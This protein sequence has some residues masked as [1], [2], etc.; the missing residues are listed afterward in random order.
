MFSDPRD[1]LGVLGVTK[2]QNLYDTWIPLKILPEN[3]ISQLKISKIKIWKK[4]SVFSVL[5]DITSSKKLDVKWH[6]ISGLFHLKLFKTSVPGFSIFGTLGPPGPHR[7]VQMRVKL[8]S[9]HFRYH[10]LETEIDVISKLNFR[11]RAN[12]WF[13]AGLYVN[14][15]LV[16][17]AIQQIWL[18][19]EAN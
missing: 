6:N 7:G 2:H 12:G 9:M 15:W 18:D 16:Y 19:E 11:I 3:R 8:I 1:P 5:R 17:N 4:F 10:N 13:L 14:A